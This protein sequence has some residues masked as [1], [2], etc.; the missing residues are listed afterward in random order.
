[1]ERCEKTY[2]GNAFQKLSEKV[3]MRIANTFKLPKHNKDKMIKGLRSK[4]SRDTLKKECIKGY[5]NPGCKN[6]IFQAGKNMPEAVYN[7]VDL[8]ARGVI[9]ML[10]KKI[11]GKRTN[12][13]KNS[14]YNKLPAKNITRARK[15]GALSGCSIKILT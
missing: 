3:S 5:C 9:S 11:F 15:Q 8:N 4:K 12:V 13:L 2:C 1:M 10:R 14:F 6:T 7:K